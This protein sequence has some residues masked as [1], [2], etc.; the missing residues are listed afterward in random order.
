MM[1]A[2]SG[3]Q[4]ELE[5]PAVNQS[6]S[7]P[8]AIRQAL[9]LYSIVIDNSEDAIYAQ[10]EQGR[11]LLF[12]QAACRFMGKTREQVLGKN[13]QALFPAAQADMLAATNRRIMATGKPETIEGFFS[14]AGGE[15]YFVVAKRPLRGHDDRI[16]G[17]FGIARDI[18]EQKRGEVALKERN[19]ELERFNRASVGRELDMI[20]LKREVNALARELG[21]PPPYDLSAI[22]AASGKDPP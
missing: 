6:A 15:R 5:Q 8:E 2:G 10:D 18:T 4:L 16:I 20:A 12:N 3:S 9:D 19:E 21:R 7:T 17:T 22:D 14:I 11:Y 13:D 1:K